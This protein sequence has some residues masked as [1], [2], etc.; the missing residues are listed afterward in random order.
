MLATVQAYNIMLRVP[1]VVN[2]V[3]RNGEEVCEVEVPE[4]ILSG[5][6]VDV[7]VS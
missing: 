2:V 6:D 4:G 1:F 7:V 5:V 3:V